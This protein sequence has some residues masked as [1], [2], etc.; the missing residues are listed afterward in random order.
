MLTPCFN[1]VLRSSQRPESNSF[2][3]HARNSAAL[4]RQARIR[5]SPVDVHKNVHTQVRALRAGEH[6]LALGCARAVKVGEAEVLDASSAGPLTAWT[7]VH[8]HNGIGRPLRGGLEATFPAFGPPPVAPEGSRPNLRGDSALQCKCVT[9]LWMSFSHLGRPAHS[10]ELRR[11][12]S[13]CP[14]PRLLRLSGR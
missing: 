3:A 14:G 2:G 12:S 6:G 10:G 8:E 7:D 13:L 4:V 1:L 5:Y 11:R 9:P